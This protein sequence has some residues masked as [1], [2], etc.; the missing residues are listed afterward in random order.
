MNLSRGLP[1]LILLSACSESSSSGP[2]AGVVDA[3]GTVADLCTEMMPCALTPGV[4]TSEVINEDLGAPDVDWFTF[5]AQE[6]QVISLVVSRET[7]ISVVALRAALLDPD[8][9]A[10][11]S[12]S[13]DDGF[14]QFLD[15]QIV[16]PK[17]GTYT[18][19]VSDVGDD[20]G[21][22]RNP[23]QV[24]V[25]LLSQSDDNEPNDDVSQAVA[26]TPGVALGGTIGT[27]GDRDWFSVTIGANQLVEIQVTATGTSSVR[28]TWTLFDPTGVTGIASST[29]P[30][31]GPWPAQVRAVGQAAGTYLLVI[32]D[33]DGADADLDRVYSIQVR[34]LAEPD[35]QDQV[36]PNETVATATQLTPGTPVT[37][38]I[39]A[40]ADLDYYAF[41]VT[42]ANG[43]VKLITVEATMAGVSPVDLSFEVLAVDQVTPDGVTVEPVCLD[44]EGP[45]D[46]RAFRLQPDGMAKVANLATAHPV[47]AD[48]TYYVL[49]R[50]FADD[51]ADQAVSYQ[52]TVNVEDEPDPNEQYSLR[53][54]Q[55]ALVAPLLTSTTGQTIE[56]D[57]VEG[58]IS[59][60]NDEDWIRYDIPGTED[61][62]M[63]S[64]G[65]WLIRFELQVNAP[66]PVELEA[67]FFGER[68]GYG[69]Y[70]QRCRGLVDGMPDP[71]QCQ[72]P[73]VENQIN[74]VSGEVLGTIG[75]PDQEC[76]VVFRE[77]T[78]RGP[79]YFRMSDLDRDDFDL[80]IPYRLRITL[81]ADCP[82]NSVCADDNPTRRMLC[83]RP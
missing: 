58:Y 57:W 25:Q 65:D 54:R 5:S 3:G 28:L 49:V 66:T 37:G 46:C 4:A 59:H 73:D 77:E 2:D 11:D 15:F 78:D 19:R 56:F 10:L 7:N 33:D 67:F 27:V 26:L 14:P 63:F 22:D 81:T 35:A 32:E 74:V 55:D 21:D 23:Y 61:P 20:D 39:A 79:H 8:N 68:R 48:G 71:D 31:S 40:N 42:G 6:G 64:N 34:L 13:G 83:E 43:S 82:A 50:D 36:A 80:A 70:G 41:N 16:A 1:L 76:F 38:Y 62:S 9:V 24:V 75:Q 18:V 60:A 53:G 45:E 12:A 29:E 17:T 51:D 47:F 72:F 44:R 52:L 69:G 30:S